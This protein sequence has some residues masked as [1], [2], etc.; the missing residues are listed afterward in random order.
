MSDLD[1]YLDDLGAKLDG[2]RPPR[3]RR[4]LIAIA[5]VA[6]AVVAAVLVMGPG[7]QRHPVDAI[8]A[9]RAA[10]E[11]DGQ[12]LHMKV[13]LELDSSETIAPGAKIAR[14]SEQWSQTDPKRWRF[15]QTRTDGSWSEVA[16]GAGTA[17]DYDSDSN[18]Q[19]NI[20]GYRDSDPQA[21]ALGLY[22]VRGGNDPDAD[23][24]TMLANGKLKDAGL[25]QADGRTVRRLQ[26]DD[27]LRGWVYD[28]DP[29]TF[30]P[31]GG[32]MTLRPPRGTAVTTRFI[33][34][35]YERLPLGADVFTIQT[36]PH[37]KITTLTKHRFLAQI[38]Q[39][40]RREKTW[41]RC[42]RR[43]HGSHKGC[44]PSPYVP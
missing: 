20:T 28:V 30:A 13:R 15:R 8:A 11:T 25:V 6:L 44:G 1:R 35:A 17:T 18:R 10:L 37:P 26:A 31:V 29:T 32:A 14:Y 4:P 21:R 39:L 5:A 42:V 40:R 43:N 22:G 7:G 12:I 2:A 19:R 38:K 34:E 16:Y 41:S 3:S 23:L 24:K 9:A 27:G 33:V 36:K